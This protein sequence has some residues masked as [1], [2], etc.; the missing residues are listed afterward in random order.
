MKALRL[1]AFFLVGLALGGGSVAAFA[2][3]SDYGRSINLNSPS[4][5]AARPPGWYGQPRYDWPDAP[6]GWGKLR[7]INSLDIGGK[8]V[9]IEGIRKFAPGTL[10]KLGAGLAKSLGPVGL[11][12]TLGELVWDEAQGWLIDPPPVE[13]EDVPKDFQAG[14]YSI[15]GWSGTFN[16]PRAACLSM[17]PAQPTTGGYWWTG[18][19]TFA[20]QRESGYDPLNWGRGPEM[21]CPSGSQDL[22]NGWCRV[23]GVDEP[24]RPVSDAELED[25]IY[26]EL[27]ARGMGSELA[28]RLV[29][30]G[31]K[32]TPDGHEANGP[33]SVPGETTTSST[34][35]PSGTT[36]T[37]STTVHNLTYNTN[38]TTNTTTVTVTN[39]TTHTTTAPDG[40]TT[41]TTETTTPSEGQPADEPQYTLDYQGSAM[42][43]IPDF[44]AQQY[45]DGFAGE[46]DKFKDKVGASPLA[47]F[48][49]GLSSGL[50]GGGTC[51][52]WSVS[53]NFGHMGNFGTHVIAP[54]CAIWPFIKAVMI[55]SALFVARRMVFGG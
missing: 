50:P 34:T 52:E 31:Y 54:P 11:G 8:R 40:T 23:A 5:G 20:C 18:N 44:Y 25:A 30:A 43:E 51:P 32:P 15:M 38:N 42:P 2:A 48:L 27:V 22:G 17:Q 53:L 41:T 49:T 35:G 46:W 13:E 47:G 9:E 24:R 6:N 12:L 10:A 39:V 3:A 19:G 29:E 7:D 4:G 21:V 55:L 1:L 37:T 16:T 14:A 28:R 36:T 45:P 33:T 26:V